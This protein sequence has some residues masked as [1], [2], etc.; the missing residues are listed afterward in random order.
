MRRDPGGRNSRDAFLDLESV[1]L[2][3]IHQV[4]RGLDFLKA[5]LTVA[6]DLIHHLLALVFHF[7]DVGR[8]FF[9]ELFETGGRLRED[10]RRQDG[11][12]R[13]EP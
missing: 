13:A 10:G 6:E 12:R 4:A 5:E 7:L 1:F 3:D 11:Q 9:L 8:G 2:Q